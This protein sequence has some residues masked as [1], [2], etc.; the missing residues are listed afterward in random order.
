MT[1]WIYIDPRKQAGDDDYLEVFANAGGAGA[2]FAEH[3]PEASLSNIRWKPLPGRSLPKPRRTHRGNAI[4]EIPPV[5][6]L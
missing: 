1:V 6:A 5:E 3:D 2:W 4:A